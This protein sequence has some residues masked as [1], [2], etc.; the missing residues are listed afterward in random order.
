M[1]ISI[2]TE[3][4]SIKAIK[5]LELN[6]SSYFDARERRMQERHFLTCNWGAIEELE[7]APPEKGCRSDIYFG[8]VSGLSDMFWA[9]FGDLEKTPIGE[10]ELNEKIKVPELRVE[11]LKQVI[12]KLESGVSNFPLE[13]LNYHV[14]LQEGNKRSA[15]FDGWSNNYIGLHADFLTSWGWENRNTLERRLIVN[16]GDSPRVLAISNDDLISLR[17]KYAD[18]F[19]EKEWSRFTATPNSFF[20]SKVLECI[21]P[22]LITGYILEPNEFCIFPAQNHIHDGFTEGFTDFDVV[23]NCL[24][25]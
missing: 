4:Q 5:P 17:D 13:I 10:I 25:N 23:L 9:Q 18:K 12:S 20:V 3:I 6:P 14:L 11:N 24:V 1:R 21:G 7:L 2:S 16:L 8:I 15:V 22:D 19:S